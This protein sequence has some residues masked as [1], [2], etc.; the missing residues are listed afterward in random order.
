MDAPSS[1]SAATDIGGYRVIRE[2]SPGRTWL[3]RAEGG[4]GGRDVVLK[5]LDD[6]CLWKGQLHPNIKDRLGRVREL[7][8]VGVANLYGVERDGGVAYMV[9]E[10]V[11]G[12]TLDEYADTDGRTHRDLLSLAR[13]LMLGVEMLHARG[14][15]HGAIKGSNVIVD[16][17][18]E[19]VTLTHVS[20]LLYGDPRE[21]V[22]A[23]VG[24]LR[25]VLERRGEGDSAAAKLLDETGDQWSPRQLAGRLGG[26]IESR[27]SDGADAIAAGD[28]ADSG[29]V[30]R[31]TLLA[32]AGVGALAVALFTGIRIYAHQRAPRPPVP[33]EAGPSLLQDSQE[34]PRTTTTP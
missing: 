17:R 7:A 20:P 4:P 16:E 9:W 21:D 1:H 26:V 5:A 15:V 24:M 3:A 25:D 31:R 13:E 29:R 10:F 30:R 27:E 32:A 19:R 2:L 33:P 18:G 14:I 23:A 22:R 6:D 11:P 34:L 12:G 28:S 8:H